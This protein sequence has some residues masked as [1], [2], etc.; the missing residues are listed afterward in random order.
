MN[1]KISEVE[2]KIPDTS[3][4]VNAEILDT[5]IGEVD[6]KIPD[7]S[8]LVKKTDYGFKALDIEKKYFTTS[9]YKIFNKKILDGKIK[10]NKL[11][12][13]FDISDIS[14]FATLATKAELK[15]EQDKIEK[16]KSRAR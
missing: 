16:F 10:E 9:D 2:N 12:D 11:A 4:L 3:G 1:R 8:G 14:K 13:Q 5:K 6:N 7:V 15:S